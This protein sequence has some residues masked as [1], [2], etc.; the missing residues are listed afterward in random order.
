MQKSASSSAGLHVF[1]RVTMLAHG[2]PLPVRSECVWKEVRHKGE[3]G[4][5]FHIAK[6]GHEKIVILRRESEGGQDTRYTDSIHSR[7]GWEEMNSS[8]HLF[9]HSANIDLHPVPPLIET[10]QWFS[11]ILEYKT[12]FSPRFSWLH[13]TVPTYFLSFISC[14]LSFNSSVQAHC[15]PFWTE[16]I[17]L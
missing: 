9:L 14:Q 2:S 8:T 3:R 1:Q 17:S 6:S 10:L 15:F 12:K 7:W 11:F 5:G 16:L 13:D 4:V